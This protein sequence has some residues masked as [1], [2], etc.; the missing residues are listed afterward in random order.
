MQN[1]ANATQDAACT[2]FATEY[3]AFL[4]KCAPVYLG[5]PDRR[6]LELPRPRELL[7]DFTATAPGAHVKPALFAAYAAYLKTAA[8][9][10]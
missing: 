1:H 3:C 10:A 6:A 8:C 9:S 5:A 7:C 4:E 2:S